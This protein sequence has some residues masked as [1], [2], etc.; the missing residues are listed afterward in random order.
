MGGHL[1]VLYCREEAWINKLRRTSFMFMCSSRCQYSHPI[2]SARSAYWHSKIQRHYRLS[3]FLNRVRERERERERERDLVWVC[4]RQTER[5]RG[6][7][8]L[9]RWTACEQAD[10]TRRVW[11]AI[12]EVCAKIAYSIVSWKR[13]ALCDVSSICKTRVTYV[14]IM[15]R[16]CTRFPEIEGMKP[17]VVSWTRGQRM[18]SIKRYIS[19][20]S[21]KHIRTGTCTGCQ[22]LRLDSEGWWF[23]EKLRVSSN[24]SECL[25]GIDLLKIKFS[26]FPTIAAAELHFFYFISRTW[27]ESL[28]S[29]F[30][31][32]KTV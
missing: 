28:R 17:R 23:L 15:G 5:G 27:S 21:K 16:P 8:I 20:H 4:F 26:T 30:Q 10:K 18:I 6:R 3:S 24:Q 22:S 29:R 31:K 14:V 11:H 9:K 19:N 2:V 25:S 7:G 32:G 1:S 13:D 12:P